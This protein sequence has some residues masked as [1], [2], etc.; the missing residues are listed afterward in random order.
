MYGRYVAQQEY[1]CAKK[2][3]ESGK[4]LVECEAVYQAPNWLQPCS[5]NT[6]LASWP[7]CCSPPPPQCPSNSAEEPETEACKCNV[8]YTGRPTKQNVLNPGYVETV[9]CFPCSS[10]TYK[11]VVGDSV[12]NAC[13]PNSFSPAGSSL[14][15][16]CT[17]DAGSK[18]CTDLLMWG[19]TT[20]YD[21]DGPEWTCGGYAKCELEGS[22]CCAYSHEY[23]NFG[24]DGS[25]MCCVCGGG[26]KHSCELCVAGKYKPTT[27]AGVCFECEAGK[28]STD[29]ATACENCPPYSN[30][31]PASTG[32]TC[33]A[34]STAPHQL[35]DLL[36]PVSSSC[37][38]NETWYDSDGPEWTCAQYTKCELGALGNDL[39][40][41]CAD[42]HEYSNFGHDASQM[43]CIW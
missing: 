15:S 11:D 31:D 21:S 36:R 41:C 38:D 7:N 19:N 39:Y 28:Y 29:G 43:C 33:S 1:L 32:C 30:P 4:C 12:C 17:C 23:I 18:Q 27:G 26:R 14:A 5:R 24:Y 20:W 37:L 42:S 40:D 10:G 16:N 34:G 8:G 35:R 2:G 6:M 22:E 13:P 25:H 9:Q 3:Q